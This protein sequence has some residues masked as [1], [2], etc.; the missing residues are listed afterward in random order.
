MFDKLSDAGLVDTIGD[1]GRAENSACARRLAAIAELYGRRVIAVEDGHGREMWRIDPW[2]AVA[3][4]VGAAGCITAAAAGSLMHNAICIRERLPRVGALFA[5]GAIDYRTVRMIVARTLLALEP[6]VLAAIDA[7]LAGA[8]PGWGPLSVLKMQQAV[9]AVVVRHDPQ[10]R[11]RTEG[12]TRGRHVDIAHDRDISHLTGRLNNAEATLLDRRLTSL[13][14]SVCDDDPRTIDQKRADAMGALAAGYAIL[15]CA[16]GTPDC[17]AGSDGDSAPSVVVHIVAE[18]AAIDSADAGTVH[19]YR[20]GDDTVEII[21]SKERL[22]EILRGSGEPD[23]APQRAPVSGVVMGGSSIPAA[24]LADLVDRGVAELREVV[25]PGA[26]PPEQRYRPSTTLAD[27]VRCR[28]LT[29]RFPGCERPAEVCDIDHTVPYDRGGLTHASN[30]KSLCRKHHLV[31]TFWSGRGGW[32][33]EQLPDGT[34]VW[35]A[36]SGHVYRTAPGS[37][38]LVPALSMPTGALES[39]LPQQVSARRG[40]MMPRRMRTR[41]ADRRHRILC[42]RQRNADA[43]RRS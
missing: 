19:G 43:A 3:A 22:G 39:P 38:L 35:T 16:C 6:D 41:A 31:K 5:T 26:S 7:E 14:H 42:E 23:N 28:D 11:R 9:D 20:P 30:L 17:P 13:A 37:A 33:D 34:V 15:A 2:E 12:R 25:H 1:A 10:A 27:F 24:V 8:M 18:A 40:V 29:C 4:E 32:H 21:A 36:P